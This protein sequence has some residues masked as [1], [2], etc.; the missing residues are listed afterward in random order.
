MSCEPGHERVRELI[1]AGEVDRVTPD[2]PIGRLDGTF[3]AG[4]TVLI[5][6]ANDR[7]SF[8]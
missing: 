1:H 6:V 2:L 5:G 3:D 4:D 7:L 8:H